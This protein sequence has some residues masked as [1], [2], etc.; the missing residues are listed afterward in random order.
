VSTRPLAVWLVG[1]GALAACEP[2]PILDHDGFELSEEVVC[3]RPT[4]GFDRLVDEAA[5]RGLDYD[6]DRSTDQLFQPDPQGGMVSA[7]DLDDDGDVDLIAGGF[8]GFPWIWENDGTGRFTRVDG[9]PEAPAGLPEFAFW[10]AVDLN[11][12][13]LP[14]LM[15]H[16]A[17]FAVLTIN[18]GGL[19]FGAVQPLFDWR[20][21]G[22]Q[23]PARPMMQASTFGDYDRDGDLDLAL[24]VVHASAGAPDGGDDDDPH[25]TPL[26]PPGLD[27]VLRNEGDSWP[28]T[29]RL[30]PS[31]EPGHAQ[32]AIWT[33]RDGDGDAD[34]FVPSEFGDRSEPS[35]FYRNEG[36]LLGEVVLINDAPEITADIEVGAMGIDAA[37]FNRDGVLDYCVSNFGPLACIVS[38]GGQYVEQA[39]AMGLQIPDNANDWMWSS[40]SIELVDLDNDGFLDFAVAAGPPNRDDPDPEHPD[41]LYRGTGPGAFELADVGFDDMRRHY[42]AASAD[43]DGDGYRELILTGTEG[44]PVLWMNTCGDGHWVEIDFAGFAGNSLGFGAQVLVTVDGETQIRELYNGRAVGQGPASLHFGLGD[45]DTIDRLEVRWPGGGVT[46]AEQVP[47]NRYI[48]AIHPDAVR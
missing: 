9:Q 2:P 23:I 41:A 7:I 1:V 42:G 28:L 20:D 10:N 19:H 36:T 25:H 30:S 8:P 22:P 48:R 31:G 13:R 16:G 24:P 18:E 26:P 12:D 6:Q 29:H 3:E 27:L 38:Q 34:L 35:A 4:A 45:H 47:A 32:V 21:Y 11:D 37:D 5:E 46:V 44:R 43:L 14:D 15:I 39:A 40:Y 33:D 17:G